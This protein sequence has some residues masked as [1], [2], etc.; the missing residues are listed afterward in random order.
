MLAALPRHHK[1]FRPPLTASFTSLYARSRVDLSK[2]G[3]EWLEE[4]LKDAYSSVDFLNPLGNHRRG[5]A[6]NA[7]IIS[8]RAAMITERLTPMAELMLN[9]TA[10]PWFHKYEVAAN[11][12]IEPPRTTARI[13]IRGS[14]PTTATI[15]RI[16]FQ[17]RK[18]AENKGLVA[19]EQ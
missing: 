9:L 5:L 10:K 4:S 2:Y 14:E 7:T 19:W 8:G 6:Y 3:Q 13:S 16:G 11:E 12:R 17:S 1:L 15:E 18:Y